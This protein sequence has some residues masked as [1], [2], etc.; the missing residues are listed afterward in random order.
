MPELWIANCTKQ[1]K[2]L[3]YR[4]PESAKVYE[5][6][7]EPNRQA[8]LP[9]G[10]MTKEQIDYFIRQH[11]P[12]GLRAEKDVRSREQIG[13]VYSIGKEV[14]MKRIGDIRTRNDAI[15]TEMVD[16]SLKQS[17]LAADHQIRQQTGDS[18]RV[19][20]LEIEEVVP[21]NEDRAGK[22]TRLKVGR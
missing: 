20:T 8:K 7:L 2:E 4:M 22:K 6:R 3:P 19:D 5:F 15:L 11:A 9:H 16:E 10:D 1:V 18:G 14:D 21:A 13:A 17:L 12:Y